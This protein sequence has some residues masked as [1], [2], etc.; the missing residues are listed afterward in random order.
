[1]VIKA[2][3]HTPSPSPSHTLTLTLTH[4][5][6]H[7]KAHA[8]RL[9]KKTKPIA[10]RL[11]IDGVSLR[12][13]T[14]SSLPENLK[15]EKISTVRTNKFVLFY[16]I[17]SP[18]SNFHPCTIHADG[19]TYNCS[20]QMYQHKKTLSLGDHT[21]A[22]KIM[23]SKDASEQKRPGDSIKVKQQKSSCKMKQLQNQGLTLMQET[24]RA[25]LSQNAT[26]KE[27]LNAIYSR[28]VLCRV[29]STRYLLVLWSKI[30]GR[31]QES[32]E[33]ERTK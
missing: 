8:K 33:L 2:H 31:G 1:M 28:I 11:T 12:R 23:N 32:V 7:K 27:H 10:D 16:S 18:Y 20:E 3:P 9:G 22:A 25:K 30:R 4:P 17:A 19:Y 15:P 29:Q 26:L 6:P 24:I 21:T 14:L 13:E 5:H